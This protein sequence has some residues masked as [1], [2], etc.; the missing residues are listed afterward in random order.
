MI[1]TI[2]AGTFLAVGLLV[3]AGATEAASDAKPAASDA[4][5]AKAIFAGGC[6]WCMEEAFDKVPGVTATISG[7][8]GG[9]V[10]NPTYEQVSSGNTGHVEA[11]MVKFDPSRVSYEKLLDVFWHNIDPT[12]A[13]GQFC[14]IGSSYHSAI[15]YLDDEQRRLAEASKSKLERTKP[16]SGEIVTSIRKATA[17]YPAEAYHQNFHEK[18][19]LR[20]TFYKHGC[21]REARLNQLWAK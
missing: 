13:N 4:S 7:Y 21:G 9:H 16:F 14:D 17:F 11:V 19:P 5:A 3:G 20:Y 15:F 2:L 1:R 8:T 10:S 18:N 6:F 12:Q